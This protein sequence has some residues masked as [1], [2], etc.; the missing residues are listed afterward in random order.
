MVFIV[1]WVGIPADVSILR[2][3]RDTDWGTCYPGCGRPPLGPLLPGYVGRVHRMGRHLLPVIT[4][5]SLGPFPAHQAFLLVLGG[6]ASG[7]TLAHLLPRRNLFG[8]LDA[9]KGL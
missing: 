7:V 9:I 5:A 4:P 1:G 3:R 8:S 6:G 2:F